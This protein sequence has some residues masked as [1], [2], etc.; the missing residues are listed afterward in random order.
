MSG[1]LFAGI[2][3][4]R[5]AVR[6]PLRPGSFPGSR[7]LG[8]LIVARHSSSLRRVA[9]TASVVA[10]VAASG[11]QTA[12]QAVGAAP[13]DPSRFTASAL[14][15]AESS[16]DVPKSVT[17]RAAKSDPTVLKRS[18]AALVAVM[19]KLDLDPVASYSGGVNGL[20]ATSPGTT[21]KS[22]KGNA[23]AVTAYRKHADKVVSTA[24]KDIA[25]AVPKAKVGRS[26]T[27]AYGGLS[28]V[29]PANQA[30]DLLA[31]D[32]VVAVQADTL[33]QPLTDASPKFVG[34]TKVWPALGGY[35]T[36]GEGVLVGILDSGIWPEHPSMADPGIDPPAGGP[37][38]CE[39]GDGSAGLGAQFECNDKLV[40]AHAFVDTYVAVTGAA[41]G[42]YCNA[43]GCSARDADGHGTHTAT[44]AA[45]S[46]VASAPILGVDRGPVSGIA[47]G[48]S[49]IAYRVCLDL[50]CYGSDSI[51]AVQQ[52]ILD[53]VDVINFSISGGADPYTDPVELAFLDATAAGISVNASAGNDGP[54]AATANHGGPWVT[55]VGASTSNRHFQATLNLTAD[56][57]D[58]FSKVG[59]TATQ[60]VA[61]APVVLPS[62]VPGYAGGAL[63]QTAFAPGSLAGKV[64][65]CQRG[66]NGRVEKGYFAS[67]GGASGMILYNPTASDTET[68]NHHLPAV[69]L[70]GPNQELLDFLAAH[71]GV[72]ATWA[73]GE[74]AAVQGDVMAGFSSRG[75][76]GDFLKPDITAPGVQIL[77]G[78]TP[79]PLTYNGG[80]AGELFQAIAGTS[81]SSPHL[82]GASALVKAAHP[83][84]T[85]GQIKSALMTSSTQDVLKE[86]GVTPAD[87]FDRG[88]GSMR[89]DSAVKAVATISETPANL[90]GAA[91]MDRV[92]LNLPSVQAN[93]LPGALTTYRTLTNVSTT[94]QQFKA[95]ATG[96]S[97]L[98]ITVKPSSFSVPVGGSTTI[99]ITLDGTASPDG[100]AFGEIK[101]RSVSK[102]TPNVVLPVTARV[103]DS[104]VPMTHTCTPTDLAPGQDA[105]CTVTLTNNSAAPA[106]VDLSLKADKRV[107]ISSVSAPATATYRG[108]MW[109]GTLTP[110]VPPTITSVAEVTP[111]ETPSGGY[112]P[113][114]GFGITPI[115][116]VGDETIS[117]F[118]V[119]AFTYGSETY[120]RIGVVS[121]GYVVIGGGTSEDV[122]YLSTPIPSTNRPNNIIAPLWSDL[123]PGAGGEV[124]I[125]L[126]TDGVDSWIVVDYAEVPTYSEGLKNTFQV[127]I[128]YNGT[129]DV[130][131]ANGTIEGG[132]VDGLSQGAENRTG[133]SGAAYTGGS[134]SLWR[135][136]T[137]P[138]TPGGS[139][140]ITYDASSAAVGTYVLTPKAT[141][142]VV[143]GTI[144]KPQ[145]LRVQ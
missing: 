123:N 81:M 97:G 13:P 96:T 36:A 101:L 134:G 55:T 104:A 30:K 31:V 130:T 35:K 109:A 59:S 115:A 78:H 103:A 5:V 61:G 63:C 114:A 40:G 53:G 52:A 75:P 24:A 33:A 69:H 90:F 46:R 139:V 51:D 91:A 47:P 137:A 93:P 125:G 34:A 80:P 85:P 66:V 141:T 145:T 127:W 65:A 94:A 86:D 132:G 131:I 76:L 17:G 67:L 113:L 128:G 37:F 68:D 22:V 119:P 14:G 116:G 12:A 21:G 108:F 15:A 57:G 126:L 1:D 118:T 138:P 25:R 9:V 84:W 8:R 73:A 42:E 74:A 79:T 11:A 58:T 120:N 19:V 49:V 144:S 83:T 28:V 82:A 71:T 4:A 100:W 64:V 45:G 3:C 26:F 88:A 105:A 32:G 89:V 7:P 43:S 62:Q 95:T 111:G 60:G 29:L 39:F 110:S 92:D 122:T 87:P 142:P 117:N 10:V 121:N 72:T 107:D 140:T 56:N 112:L 143:K 50:G 102:R 98:K 23:G 99:A 136:S 16:Y 129:D 124:R 48:A 106:D 44:T 6:P 70:E 77:A 41:P 54:G 135:V 27:T 38:A 20:A 18:D 2:A 133:T